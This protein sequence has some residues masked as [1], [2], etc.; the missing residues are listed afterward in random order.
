MVLTTSKVETYE[1]PTAK[2]K[3][4]SSLGPV[5]FDTE[6]DSLPREGSTVKRN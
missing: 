2:S 4:L 5:N 6:Q 1:G 3:K